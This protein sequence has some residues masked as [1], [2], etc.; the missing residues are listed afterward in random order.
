MYW[1]ALADDF[2][3]FLILGGPARANGLENRWD[4]DWADPKVLLKFL[5]QGNPVQA[6]PDQKLA[7]TVKVQEA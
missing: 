4:L 7:A 1:S 3:T 2:V 5:T 6:D